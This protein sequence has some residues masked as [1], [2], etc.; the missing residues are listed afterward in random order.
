[1]LQGLKLVLV[2]VPSVDAVRDFYTEKLGLGVADQMPGFIQFE[3]AGNG[4]ALALSERSA[5]T[6][7][8]GAELW[9][10]VDNADATCAVFAEQGVAIVEPLDD[11]PFGRTFAVSDPVGNRHYMLQLA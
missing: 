4:A 3:P 7:G 9:W 11:K 5:E 6:A 2:H 10:Y 1:M 8:H